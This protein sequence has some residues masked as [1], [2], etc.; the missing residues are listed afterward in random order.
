MADLLATISCWIFAN[1]V[2]SHSKTTGYLTH[3]KNVRAMD[4]TGEMSIFH[5]KWPDAGRASFM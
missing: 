2:M 3:V 5:P 4:Y 1:E